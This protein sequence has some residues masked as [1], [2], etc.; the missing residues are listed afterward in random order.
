MEQEGSEKD[1][2]ADIRKAVYNKFM[3]SKEQK[4]VVHDID[5]QRSVLHENKK[6]NASHFNLSN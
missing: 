3:W 4:M 5:V 1:K 6:V 2:V